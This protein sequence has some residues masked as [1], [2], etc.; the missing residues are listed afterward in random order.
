AVGDQE[1]SVSCAVDGED[2]A[3]FK[4]HPR[5]AQ[6]LAE[7]GEGAGGIVENRVHVEHARCPQSRTAPG[8]LRGPSVLRAYRASRYLR[9]VRGLSRFALPEARGRFDQAMILA[10]TPAPTVR[11][12]SRMAKRSFSSMAIGVIS[13]TF[14]S[15]LSPGMIIS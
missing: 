3:A 11:P 1:M 8:L 9:P 14:S 12:P 13:S 2:P 15:A 6:D 7:P 4:T 10:T 5:S